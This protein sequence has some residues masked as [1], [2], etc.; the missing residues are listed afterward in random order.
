M[1]EADMELLET[2]AESQDAKNKGI[3]QMLAVNSSYIAAIMILLKAKGIVS[4][5]EMQESLNAITPKVCS[6]VPPE[7]REEI[8]QRIVTTS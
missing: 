6:N 3:A 8:L 1:N 2:L 4:D 5:E 7:Y